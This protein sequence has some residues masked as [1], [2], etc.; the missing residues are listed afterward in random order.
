MPNNDF[1]TVHKR[2]CMNCHRA[3]FDDGDW[4]FVGYDDEA[5]L[6]IC[7]DCQS[8][9]I[10]INDALLVR[11]PQQRTGADTSGQPCPSCGGSGLADPLEINLDD[12]C[13]VCK[14]TGQC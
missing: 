8:I 12:V 4:Q 14:G 9:N 1:E 7:P 10:S 6:H 5:E 2:E 13:A 11:A 3:D